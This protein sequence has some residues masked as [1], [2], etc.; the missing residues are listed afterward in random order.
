MID[1]ASL[2][3]Y[4]AVV[5]GFVFIPDLPRC[6]RSRAR[7]ARARRSALPPAPVSRRAT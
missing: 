2:I 5:F 7:P 1:L 3:T 6:L 4:I